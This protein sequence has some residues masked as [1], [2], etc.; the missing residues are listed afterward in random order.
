MPSIL[1]VYGSAVSYYTGKLEGYL[2]YKEIPYTFIPLSPTMQRRLKKK[3][4]TAQIPAIELPDGRFMTDT[5]PMIDFFEAAHPAPAVIPTDPL[6]AFMSRLVEDYAEEWLWRPAMHYRWS[7]R[8]DALLLSRKIVDEIMPGVPLPAIIKRWG[9]RKRQHGGWVRGD[10]VTL[11]T[12]DHVEGS[13]L[14]TLDQLEVIFT[15]RPYLLGDKP[16]LGDFGF[17]L[18]CFDTSP[19]TP[20][21]L[22]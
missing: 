22:T 6:Q 16:T 21:R 12:W 2:R 9:I 1:T 8:K 4:G 5:T 14:K 13:Y 19:R 20:L 10:G 17:L 7:Y 15:A 11:D 18:R 3:T